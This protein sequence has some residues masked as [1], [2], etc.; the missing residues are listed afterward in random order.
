MAL[1]PL[2]TIVPSLAVVT[3]PLDIVLPPLETIIAPFA[4][5]ALLSDDPLDTLFSSI[6]VPLPAVVTLP[7][8]D[9]LDVRLSLTVVLPSLDTTIVR[10][11]SARPSNAESELW[12]VSLLEGLVDEL[13]ESDG[14]E[15]AVLLKE[16]SEFEL[17]GISALESSELEETLAED[18]PVAPSKKMGITVTLESGIVKEYSFALTFF[19]LTALLWLFATAIPPELYPPLGVTAM[20]TELPAVAELTEE[21]AEPFAC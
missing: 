8:V 16:A 13:D 18:V 20:V 4:V 15:A 14:L 17:A 2:E 12:F 10:V 11:G 5:V 3:L 21:V 19:V 9:E 7:P 1:L 6:P